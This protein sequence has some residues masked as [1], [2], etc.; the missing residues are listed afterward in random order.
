MEQTTT[1]SPS[2]LWA[3]ADKLLDFSNWTHITGDMPLPRVLHNSQLV[4]FSILESCHGELPLAHHF[5]PMV[6]SLYGKQGS[7]SPEVPC[8]TL[9]PLGS[10][11]V[12]W[13]LEFLF[14]FFPCFLWV[15][16]FCFWT[17][18]YNF[19]FL[20]IC[21]LVCLGCFVL[22]LCF[23]WPSQALTEK[24]FLLLQAHMTNVDVETLSSLHVV[25]WIEAM[26]ASLYSYFV[27]SIKQHLE[28]VKLVEVMQSK[29]LKILKNV[30]I[31]WISMLS[32]IV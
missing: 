30:I 16:F 7:S 23:I 29:G 2:I 24:C 32:L 6:P 17:L 11:I 15:C 9:G 3:D 12:W 26:L 27:H 19:V 10:P 25:L 1:L 13:V 20:F 22:L 5:N 14:L 31:W 8:P 28:F 18:Y 21:G 4:I